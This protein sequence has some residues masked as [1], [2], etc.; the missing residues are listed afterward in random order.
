MTEIET[1]LKEYTDNL[2]LAEL[3]L[4]D[5]PR[6]VRPGREAQKR[7]AQDALPDLRANYGKA[8]T[9][10][11]FGLL[12]SG[13]GSEEFGKIAAQEA[14]AIVVDGAGLYRRLTDRVV[15]AMGSDRQFGVSH[16]SAVIQELRAVAM[17]LNIHSMPS[18]IWSEPVNVGDDRGLLNHVRGMVDS[19]VGLDLQALYLNRQITEA[20]IKGGFDKNTVPVIVTDTPPETADALGRKLFAEGRKLE[21]KT[22]SPVTKEF[23]LDTFEQVK[24]QLKTNKKK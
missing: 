8:L 4:D 12:V 18:P 20:G 19:S 6:S 11:A 9:K 17:E 24:K 22:D 2:A 7:T 16:Y 13:P 5:V 14:D 3:N 23:V 15:Q 10:A 1:A 21:V